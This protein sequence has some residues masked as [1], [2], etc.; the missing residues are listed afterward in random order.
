MS[1]GGPKV[2]VLL[3]NCILLLKFLQIYFLN[4]RLTQQNRHIH[5]IQ[6]M[7]YSNVN[8]ICLINHQKILRLLKHMLAK[9]KVGINA[10]F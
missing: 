7:N 8:S 5:L 9:L 6:I 10:I 2:E 1:E 3:E 4:N